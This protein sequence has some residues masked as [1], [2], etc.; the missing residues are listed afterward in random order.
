MGF[1]FSDEKDLIGVRSVLDIRYIQI[2]RRCLQTLSAWPGKEVGESES[3]YNYIGKIYIFL[4][5]LICLPPGVL[6]IKK[7]FGVIDFLELGHTYVTVFINITSLIRLLLIF[8]KS[9]KNL[10]G[11]FIKKIHLFNHKHLSEYAMSTYIKVHKVSH[12]FTMYLN[13]MVFIGIILF[14]ATPIYKNISSGAFS[15]YKT[16]NVTFEH[17]V[18]FELPFDYKHNI[19]G[20]LV[21]FF[22][23]WYMS[24]V[25]SSCFS[26]F[27]LLMSL[28]IFHIC[29]HLL[30]LIDNLKKFRRPSMKIMVD[31]I[32][33]EWY[34]DEEM[35]LVS[36]DLRN[37]I[38]HHNLIVEFIDRMSQTF[39]PVLYLYYMF[40]IINGCVLLLECS[41]M[42]AEAL[43]RYGTLTFVVFQQLIQIS[44]V[45]ELLGISSDKLIDAVYSV[46]W[47]CMDKP[48]RQKVYIILI[49]SQRSLAI[50]AVDMV[51][52]GVQ[53][54]ALIIRT[55]LS[56]F[57][58]LR[59]FAKDDIL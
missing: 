16:G 59:T 14:N 48:N 43:A 57:I 42:S 35:K 40:H 15:N 6:Y 50:K 34:S 53:T 2:L 29:G 56:Y 19:K 22:F 55:S 26:N 46:P 20:Y 28:M 45:F 54:M 37:I 33:Y 18:Y 8:M 52:V 51:D 23:D 11:D 47:E 3:K 4:I 30:I 21:I 1:Y 36:R 32:E 41:Q 24:F 38:L 9:Y 13:T 25:C 7:Y 10:V 58:M 49:K 44:I 5:N 12:F 39:G 17:S 27:D 31:N